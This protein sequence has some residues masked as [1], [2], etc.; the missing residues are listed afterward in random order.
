MFLG[1]TTILM[2]YPNQ[3]YTNNIPDPFHSAFS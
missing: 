2:S 1:M 3:Y